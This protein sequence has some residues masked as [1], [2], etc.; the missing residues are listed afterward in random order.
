MKKATRFIFDKET[1]FESKKNSV[2]SSDNSQHT[3]IFAHHE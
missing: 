1:L 3:T 2:L